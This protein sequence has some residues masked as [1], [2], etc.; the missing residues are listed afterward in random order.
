MT[1][2][3][4]LLADYAQTGSEA[5]FRELV[6]RY[7]DLVYSAAV[8]LMGGDTHQAQDVA[9]IVFADL[10]RVAQ[11]LPAEVMLGGWLH[12]RT[13]HVAATLV[14]SRRRRESR[15]RQAADMNALPDHSEA[16][17]ARI[18]PLLDE[19]INQLSAADRT[20]ILLRFFEHKDFRAIGFALGSNEDAAQKRVSRALEKLHSHLER[21]GIAL[22]ATAVGAVLAGEVVTAA[23]AGLAFAISSAALASAAGGSGTT[24]TLIKLIT[25]SKLKFGIICAIAAVVATPLI[26]QHEA[27]A[28]LRE[29]N[30]ALR[31]KAVENGQLTAENQALSQ[32][33][34]D[35]KKSAH[36]T[37]DQF[38]ELARLRRELQ[39][40]RTPKQGSAQRGNSSAT[41]SKSNTSSGDTSS[42]DS[43]PET[44]LQRILDAPT[45]L[46]L[47]SIR[48]TNAGTATPEAT[49]QTFR[50]AVKNNDTATLAQTVAWGPGL[51]AKA[52][53][54]FD[55]APPAAQQQFS[56]VDGAFYS[57]MNSMRA[58]SF[59]VVSQ[60]VVGDDGTLIVQE[61]GTDGR[62]LQNLIQM[63]LF[64]D[65]WRTL[66][67]SQMMG[68]LANYLNS[69]ALWPPPSH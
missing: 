67:P 39:T 59:G 53:A 7:L 46:L 28:K 14:R 64:S 32:E 20:A 6:S 48:W 65:G 21:R 33:L 69:P 34:E 45:V 26:I 18:A 8:R 52:Q 15:E 49:W 5:A 47:P 40:L 23:P 57:F 16:N 44:Q 51:E 60:N 10:A 41:A 63:H 19:A 55:S 24:L 17:L 50:W 56:T 54:L 30:G 3:R 66:V 68:P 9:Q 42:A 62:I 12:R 36:L 13:C 38:S 25:M 29:E 61:Q 4:K 31:Q 2:A 22:A 58:E 37:G 35:V 1:D 11:R 43:K 27:V